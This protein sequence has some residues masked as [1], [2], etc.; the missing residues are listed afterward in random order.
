VTQS[1]KNISVRRFESMRRAFLSICAFALAFALLP[2]SASAQK[3]W[4]A[5]VG[6]ETK[7]H[8]EQAQAFLPNEVW[9]NAGDSIQWTFAPKNEPHTVTLLGAGEVRPAP[10][11][12]IGPKAPPP[13]V[14]PPFFFQVVCPSPNPY[15]GGSASYDGSACVSSA[16]LNGGAAPSTFTVTFP[17]K[18]NYKMVCLIHT[19]MNGTVHVLD[20]TAQLPYMQWDYDR[21]ARDQAADILRGGDNPREEQRDFRRSQNEV[22]MTGEVVATG[23]GREYLSFSRFFHGTIYIHAGETVEWTNLDPT[24]PHTVTFGTE[25]GNPQAT[26]G[27]NLNPDPDGALAATINSTTDSVSSG[28]LQ[29]A[30]EDAVNRAP[31]AP[32]TTRIRITFT[33]A[34]TYHYICALHDVNGMLGT[35]VVK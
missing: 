26:V 7:D 21:Q 18:G 34:G 15:N 20:S 35:V 23:G 33:H 4:Y 17:K 31:S 13:P 2:Q 1:R 32:G 8:A 11:F 29:A 22:I 12:P 6:A 14:A 19:N 24:E 16:A 27:L 10:P 30:P 25:P 28:F 9:I 3:T 5:T